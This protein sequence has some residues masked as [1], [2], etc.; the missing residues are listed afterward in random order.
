M[1]DGDSKP[2][3]DSS[4]ELEE[5]RRLA[6]AGLPDKAIV[7]YREVRANTRDA[8]VAAEAWRLEAFAL[9]SRGRWSEALEAARASQEVARKLERSDLLAEGLNAE[10]AVH[11]GRGEFHDAV[12]LY[13]AM[14][15]VADA[16]RIRGLAYQ[17]LGIIEARREAPYAAEQR[18]LQAYEEFER[19]GYD[20][21]MA[22]V[23]NNRAAVALDLKRFEVAEAIARE[24]TVMARRVNDHDLL[25]VAT[26]N[27]AEALAGRG[28]VERAEYHASTALGYFDSAGNRWRKVSCYEIL[29]DVNQAQ[30]ESELARRFWR[31]GLE[32][33]RELGATA[34]A[35]RLQE[36]LR[37]SEPGS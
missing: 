4:L 1:A 23:L 17:N 33:A 12:R 18:L 5:A 16:P 19:A 9:Q 26:L 2:R 13:H 6:K 29:G 30:G 32:L 10:A 11:F 31:D 22:H 20:W 36:R 34:E 27:Y 14:L 35:E 8:A 15:E 21:G 28:D 37:R 25:A 3:A 24:A 7:L